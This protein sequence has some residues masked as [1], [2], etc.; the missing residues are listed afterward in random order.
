MTFDHGNYVPCLRWKQGEYQALLRLSPSTKGCITPLIE[1]P[2]IGWDFELGREAKTI[3]GHLLSIRT[4]TKPVCDTHIFP[5]TTQ[6]EK[7][8]GRKDSLHYSLFHQLLFQILYM[9]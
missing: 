3:D 6:R 7:E 8:K 4:L 2:E 5:P 9:H 1:V